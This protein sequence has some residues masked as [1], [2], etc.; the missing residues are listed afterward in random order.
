MGGHV[1]Q[2]RIGDVSQPYLVNI[3]HSNL[4]KMTSLA[5]SAIKS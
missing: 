4:E 5:K 2:D 1:V 3:G